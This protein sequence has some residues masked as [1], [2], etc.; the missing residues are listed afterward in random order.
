[1]RTL[2]HEN[3]SQC[4]RGGTD[5]HCAEEMGSHGE[6]RFHSSPR[7]IVYQES[8]HNRRDARFAESFTERT[9]LRYA[10]AYVLH[11]PGWTW[12]QRKAAGKTRKGEILAGQKDR[13]ANEISGTKPELT[14]DRN[15]VD[16]MSTRETCHR[17]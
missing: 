15:C 9:R 7:G 16:G 11:K 8:Q 5:D 6:D 10:T 12:A 14:A 4:Q 13:A 17:R 3:A 2:G 1:M